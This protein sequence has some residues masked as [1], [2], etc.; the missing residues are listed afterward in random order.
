MQGGGGG[1]ADSQHTQQQQQQQQ[2]QRAY[3]VITPPPTPPPFEPNPIFGPQCQ[4][5]SRG[6]IINLILVGTI[7]MLVA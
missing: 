4:A 6:V 7:I 2:Q 1:E 5:E 3:W